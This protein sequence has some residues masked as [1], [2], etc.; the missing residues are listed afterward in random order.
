MLVG[1]MYV[2][3]RG[4]SIQVLCP[5]VNCIVRVFLDC[6]GIF[7]DTPDNSKYVS[8]NVFSHLVHCILL[9]V[10]FAVQ[11]LFSLM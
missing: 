7:G 4:V 8:A 11:N 6:L 3:L 10:S 1:H 2:L 5:F 9:M